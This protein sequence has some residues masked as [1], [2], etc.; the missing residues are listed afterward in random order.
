[1]TLSFT[2]RHQHQIDGEPL[3]DQ[4]LHYEVLKLI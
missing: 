2:I 4:R 3:F 1:M